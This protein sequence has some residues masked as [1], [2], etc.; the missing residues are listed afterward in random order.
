MKDT[1]RLVAN[2]WEN[3]KLNHVETPTSF[4]MLLGCVT[5]VALFTT[6]STARAQTLASPAACDRACLTKYVDDYALSLVKHDPSGLPLAMDV[7]VTE[8]GKPI[9]VGEGVWKSAVKFY[10]APSSTQYVQDVQTGQVAL[11]GVID[12]GVPAM[13]AVR[14]QIKDGKITEIENLVKRENDAGGPFQPEGYLWREAPFIREIPS[15]LRSSRAKLAATA[16][17]YWMKAVTTHKGQAYMPDCIHVENGMNTDW[18]RPLTSWEAYDVKNN[19]P[20]VYDGRIWTCERELNLT[21]QNWKTV[22]PIRRLIDE[23]RGLVLDW[24]LVRREGR[25]PTNPTTMPDGSPVIRMAYGPPSR[26]PDGW[27]RGGLGAVTP[28]GGPGAGAPAG[29]ATT[30]PPTTNYHAQLFRI[31]NGKISREQVFWISLPAG[32]VAPF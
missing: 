8:N 28:A 12:V 21:T 6:S 14:L 5:A 15:K 24:N 29:G 11:M 20:S 18:E 13:Y 17:S 7:K 19:M 3:M 23:E 9:Q 4:T 22:V 2:E 26:G 30:P 1:K 31:V 10:S 25:G 16:D 32:A 27:P